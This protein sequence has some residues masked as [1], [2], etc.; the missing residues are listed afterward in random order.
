MRHVKFVFC[1]QSSKSGILPLWAPQ[2]GAA[3]FQVLHSSGQFVAI[4]WT[5]LDFMHSEGRS[6]FLEPTDGLDVGAGGN[7]RATWSNA[8]ALQVRKQPQFFGEELAPN[9]SE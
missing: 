7:L 5:A 6:N 4:A 2:F 9:H 3:T 8:F 1:T